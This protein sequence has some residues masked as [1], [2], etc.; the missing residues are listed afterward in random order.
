MRT[1]LIK[2]NVEIVIAHS[3]GVEENPEKRVI[4]LFF[5]MGGTAKYRR[6]NTWNLVVNVERKADELFKCR[7]ILLRVPKR[8]TSPQKPTV[9]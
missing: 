1:V 9:A 7:R 8:T 3:L 5:I 2:K 4:C 6:M